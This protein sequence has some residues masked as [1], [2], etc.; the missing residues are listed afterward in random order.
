MTSQLQAAYAADPQRTSGLGMKEAARKTGFTSDRKLYEFLRKYA[1]FTGTSPPD[2]L[3][4]RGLFF[5]RDSYFKRGPVKVPTGTT[6]C[7]TAGLSYITT[8]KNRY[9]PQE[10]QG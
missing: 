4:K 8:L 3:V 5:I 10:K 2:D 6:K 7:T 9:E 1:G